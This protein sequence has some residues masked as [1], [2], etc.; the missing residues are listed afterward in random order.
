MLRLASPDGKRSA[1]VSA[2]GSPVVVDVSAYDIDNHPS[3][4][5]KWS[6]KAAF[7]TTPS[8]LQDGGAFAGWTPDAG[9]SL[10]AFLAAV[11]S[12]AE[13]DPFDGIGD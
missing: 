6:F 5:P 4:G 3:R 7:K 9:A 1:I 12:G 13:H 10:D 8:D 11:R 2:T